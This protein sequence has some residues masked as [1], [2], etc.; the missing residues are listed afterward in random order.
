M[1]ESHG[2][3]LSTKKLSYGNIMFCFKL[4]AL[5]LLTANDVY[6]YTCRGDC[7]QGEGDCDSNGDCI[8]G[9]V[10]EFDGW[11]GDDYCRA[12]PNTENAAN[13]PFNAV[14]MVHKRDLGIASHQRTVDIL[15][16]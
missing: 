16:R 2:A 6:G 9:L 4:L 3:A 12:G 5:L 7:A 15:V 14:Q 13:A 11:W 8:D 10:C 1:G